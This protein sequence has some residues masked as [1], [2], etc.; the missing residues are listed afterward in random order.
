MA[1]TRNEI[2]ELLRLEGKD[3]EALFR[4]AA[5]LR[6][7]TI[8][9]KVYLRG[10]IEYGNV[11]TKDCLYCGIRRSGDTPRYTLDRQQV[12]AAARFAYESG[13]GSIVIQGGEIHSERHI[14][15][16]E[17][18][19]RDV[20]ALSSGRL[21]VTLSLGE[22]SYETYA[23]WREAGAH[24]YLLRIEA[25]NRDL[26]A[27]IHPDDGM[28]SFDRRVKALED[29]RETGYQVGTGVMV[30]LPWQTTGDLADDL[31]FMRSI[32]ID[33]CGMGPYIVSDGTPLAAY[34]GPIAPPGHRLDMTLKM[35]S[36]LRLMMP[37]INIAAATALQAI[38]RDGR[39]TALACGAN[40]IMPNISPEDAKHSYTLYNG[41]STVA[42][43]S[44]GDLQA[45]W[46]ENGDSLHFRRR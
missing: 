7:E 11:C 31:L 37:D 15:T 25:S 34:P 40:V 38:D 32:D 3:K 18:L 20:A 16:I 5:A 30:G 39:R 46:N 29:L 10:L 22:Q 44:I 23:R 21:G 9:T 26:Y 41:K 33:M 45:A 4:E 27:K 14:D 19:L 8:G 17:Q 24:R 43:N 1:Y 12:L 36:V 13:Y 42:D 28:H 2:I 35:I 6:D